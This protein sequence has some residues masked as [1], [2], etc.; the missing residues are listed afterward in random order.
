MKD[1]SLPEDKAKVLEEVLNLRHMDEH[2]GR[3]RKKEV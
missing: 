2:T 1:G 3:R